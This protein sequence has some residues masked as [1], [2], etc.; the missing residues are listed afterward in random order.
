MPKQSA[1]LDRVFHALAGPTRRAVLERLGRGPAS[2]TD[3]ADAFDMALPS[4]AQ[5][6]DVLE[7]C[8]LVSSSKKGRVRTYRLAPKALEPVEHWLTKQR[9]LWEKR[10]DQL[11]DYL[12]TL[13]EQQP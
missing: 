2:V 12:E 3:L 6:L 13:K 7:D 1:Q 9:A 5:H 8:G 10:L 11:D 4:F